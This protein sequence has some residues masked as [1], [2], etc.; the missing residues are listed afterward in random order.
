MSGISPRAD[1]H[2]NLQRWFTTGGSSNKSAQVGY[3]NAQF[4]KLID[5][6]AAV[7][8][9]AKAKQLYHEAID[10]L[11]TDAVDIFHLFETDLYGISDR[12]QNFH[13][14]PDR[15]IR[16]RDLWLSK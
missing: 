10:I 14:I 3:G 8:D 15:E 9:Q 12:V 6:A 1:P 11:T 7:Y 13:T 4:D 16:L 2:I 5:E